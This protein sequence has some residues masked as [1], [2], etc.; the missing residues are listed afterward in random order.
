MA[1]ITTTKG[2]AGLT[3][4][5]AIAYA[6]KQI[7]PDVCAAYPITPSTGIVE[8]FSSYVADGEVDTEFV[9]VESEH[10]AM[11]ACIGASAAGARVMTATSSQGLALMWEMLYI[12]SGMRLPI[13]LTDVNRA[14]SAPINIHCD[15]SDSMGARDSGWIQLYSETVQEAYDNLF[16]AV[17]IA[18]NENVLLPVMVCLDGFITSHA[19]ENI[20]LIDDADVKEFIGEYKPQHSLLDTDNPVTYGAM[21][22]PDTYIEFKHQQSEAIIRAKDV[23]S[24]IG[25][26]F[27]NK[28]GREYGL[29]EKYR[30]DDAE[31][32]IVIFSSA[33]G[34][35]KVAVDELRKAG[36]KVGILR[37]RLF[38]PFPFKE[39]ADAL[40]NV[41]AV[42]VLDRADSMNGFGG[43]LFNEV[44]SALY[45]LEK[46]PKVMSRVFG[47]GGRDYKVKDA[48][49][50][51]EE[52]L[53]IAETGKV[54]TLTKYI[55]M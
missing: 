17:R 11:S 6:M 53:K 27:G 49:G 7:N 8:E 37:P 32:A 3:G 4:N 22:L 5:S 48:A 30:L 20:S 38:R 25:M 26:E 13:V 1:T 18:E 44:R 23:V 21:T 24:K 2:Q 36:K 15:H 47:L 50:V 28:F 9:T 45:E 54:E 55:T 12:A 51:F 33:A 10:S 29:M 41:K 19:I 14:L 16:Q 46:R 34:T 31:A 35:T 43:P 52:L 39:I 40:K 42:A